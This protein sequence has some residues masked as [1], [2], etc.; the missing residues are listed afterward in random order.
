[1]ADAQE[2]ALA[3]IR[4]KLLRSQSQLDSLRLDMDAFSS[5]V[6]PPFALGDPKI[7]PDH[8]RWVYP[9]KLRRP[10]PLAWA[11]V[12]G[13]V[14]HDLRSALDHCIYQLT[15]DSRGK[16]LQRTGFPISDKPA[17]WLQ[18][19]GKKTADNPLGFAEQCAMYQIRGVGKGVVDYI[20][21]LQPHQMANPHTSALW[22]LHLLWNQ[23]KHRLLLLWGVQL[24]DKGSE[25]KVEGADRPGKVTL[26]RGLLRDGNDAVTTTF[27]GPATKGT[28][29][30]KL[31][32]SLAFAN[33]ADKRPDVNDRLWRIHDTT[34]GVVSTLI[35][36]I[37]RQDEPIP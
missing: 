29:G 7:S 9:L 3:G 23:D 19:G 8:S 6:P 15:L 36:A 11:V 21:R 25:L 12:L 17:N 34:A 33:P 24:N 13:E 20:K 1:M 5:G 31:N 18:H 37:G 27:Q 28:F 35:A 16:E 14:V 26:A 10:M 2:E 22:S 30:G 4:Q 32:M